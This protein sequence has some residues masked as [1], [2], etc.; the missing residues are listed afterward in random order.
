MRCCG[1]GGVAEMLMAGV[2]YLGCCGR[3]AVLGYCWPRRLVGDAD[4]RGAVTEMPMAG[5]AYLGCCWLV[6]RAEMLLAGALQRRAIG[7]MLLAG[8]RAEMLMS[9]APWRRY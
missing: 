9:G 8:G 5:V 2:A 6:R 4:G 1:Q 7:K 3:G